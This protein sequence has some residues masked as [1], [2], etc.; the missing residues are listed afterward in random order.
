MREVNQLENAVDHRIAER[1][2][3]INAAELNADKKLLGQLVHGVILTGLNPRASKCNSPHSRA[4][5][6]P[7]KR[8]SSPH[9]GGGLH[10]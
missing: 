4:E 1:N 10:F 9:E 3:R 2:Q 7:A 6:M 5:K 8:K